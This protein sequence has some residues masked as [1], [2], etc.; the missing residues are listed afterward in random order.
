LNEVPRFDRVQTCFTDIKIMRMRSRNSLHSDLLHLL[1]YKIPNKHHPGGFELD[2]LGNPRTKSTASRKSDEWYA[3]D[4]GA[5]G[6]RVGA[7]YNNFGAPPFSRT[8]YGTTYRI[9]EG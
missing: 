3:R 8:I 1:L 9:D 5:R 4:S 7:T 2:V 6:L